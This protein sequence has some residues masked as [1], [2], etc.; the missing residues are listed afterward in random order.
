MLDGVFRVLEWQDLAPLLRELFYLLVA[1]LVVTAAA[2][3][4][5]SSGR[6]P[7]LA[8]REP[9]GAEAARATF[10]CRRSGSPRRLRPQGRRSPMSGLGPREQLPSRLEHELERAA[11]SDQDLSLLLL[12]VEPG[13]GR[14]LRRSSRTRC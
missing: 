11:S 6:K 2:L 13:T 1:Y 4:A 5:V 7:A 10:R 12:A 14:R 8:A 9:A 3:V